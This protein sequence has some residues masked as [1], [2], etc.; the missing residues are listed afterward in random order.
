MK[1]QKDLTNFEPAQVSV[2][3][4]QAQFQQVHSDS[5]DVGRQLA[6]SIDMLSVG[7]V[8]ETIANSIVEMEALTNRKS[9][10][11]E[12]LP[13]AGKY[14]AKARDTAKTEMLQTG[15]M[16]DTVDRLFLTLKNKN[17]NVMDVMKRIYSMR[18]HTEQYI[19]VLLDQESG[20]EDFLAVCPD[21]FDAQKARNLLV[22]VK[23]AIVKA[24]DRLAVMTGTLNSASVASQAISSM[25]PQLQGEL[26]TELAI[27]AS[28]NELKEFKD[29]F[30]T[31]LEMVEELNH[32]NNQ[33]I[34]ETVLDVGAMS[35]SNPKNLKRLEQNQLDRQDMHRKLK[36]QTDE[37]RKEQNL[38]LERF[39][40]LQESQ[41]LV[42]DN[43]LN[44]GDK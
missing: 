5:L 26:Q 10:F 33:Q 34:Q 15:K 42:L 38:A 37:A 8:K 41:L 36:K 1:N 35:I 30:D 21:N 39:S 14:L 9:S 20:I 43:P 12:K 17:D 13:W 2:D 31:T 6:E 18:E 3:T 40:A 4:L 24:R 44:K 19:E 22:Q 27:K 23:P 32:A 11:I 7:D 16:V 28:M 29:I 25:L